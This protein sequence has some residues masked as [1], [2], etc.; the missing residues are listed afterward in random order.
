[1]A[2][3]ADEEMWKAVSRGLGESEAFDA[4]GLLGEQL[5]LVDRSS[6]ARG[7]RFL[8]RCRVRI[9]V[10]RVFLQRRARWWNRRTRRGSSR[11][12]LTSP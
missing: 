10:D 4:I 11:I 5:A 9:A 3:T 12:P 6:A 2:T 8:G 7:E 1:M